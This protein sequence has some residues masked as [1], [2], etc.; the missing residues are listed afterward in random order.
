MES[1]GF[2]RVPGVPDGWEL[3]RI[4]R[5]MCGEFRVSS[6]GKPVAVT[7]N[8][9]VAKDCPIIRK[10]EEPAKYR[11][12]ESAAEYVA[13]R[14]ERF[15]VDWKTQTDLAPGF[16]A[17]VSANEMFV[18]VAFGDAIEKLDWEE[19]FESLQ[20]RHADNSTSPFGIEVTE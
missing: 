14:L 16:F 4:G 10:I 6:I 2:R 5:P 11:P 15:A 20:F 19:A 13:N 7:D 8:E 9:I 1:Q 12:F 3:V 17:V 18:W